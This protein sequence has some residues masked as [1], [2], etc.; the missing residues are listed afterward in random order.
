[1]ESRNPATQSDARLR[2]L[3]IDD[4]KNIRT[5]LSI[6]LQQ[7]ACDVIA[8]GSADAASAAIGRQHFDLA[9]LDVRL[10]SADGLE[11]IPK[12]LGENPGLLVIVVTAYATIDSAVEA[13]KRGAT[14]YL[15]K[16]FTPAQIRHVIDQCIQKR[17]LNRRVSDL[18][19]RLEE[20]APEIDLDSE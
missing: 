4:E 16:P 11:L 15:P 9:F 3:V 6:C 17:D 8:V 20:A 7:L 12:M 13:M 5:T 10:G 14:D 18:E 1:M 19:G 2:V